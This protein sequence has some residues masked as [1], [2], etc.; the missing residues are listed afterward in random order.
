M[1]VCVE[2][3]VSFLSTITIKIPLSKALNPLTALAKL[4]SGCTRQPLGVTVCMGVT[5]NITGSEHAFSGNLDRISK[6]S[7]KIRLHTHG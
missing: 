4:F 5:H 1:N 3:S 6:T 2:V 7:V